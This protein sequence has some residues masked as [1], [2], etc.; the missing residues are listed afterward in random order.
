MAKCMAE[1]MDV[2]IKGIE[3]TMPEHTFR[4]TFKKEVTYMYSTKSD[5]WAYFEGSTLVLL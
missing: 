5:V 2:G 3:V 4:Q 1:G